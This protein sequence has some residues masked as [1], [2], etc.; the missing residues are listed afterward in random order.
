ME[1]TVDKNGNVTNAVPG[2]KGSTTLNR[3]LLSE[4]KKAAMRSKFD[5]APNAP[6]YQ[7]GTVTYRFILN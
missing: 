4:A 6:A 5:Q 3:Y 2:V 7:Q 1:I